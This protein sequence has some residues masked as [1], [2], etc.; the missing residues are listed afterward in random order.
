MLYFL[1]LLCLSTSPNWA[2]LNQMPAEVLGFWRL[3]LAALILILFQTL[4]SEF[5]RLKMNRQNIWVIVSGFFFF[6][7]LWTYKYAA[8]HTTISTMMVMF[9]TNPIWASVGSRI[10]FN[11]K[12]ARRV[13][14]AYFLALAGVIV[15]VY[16][17]LSF[18]REHTNGNLIALISA[19]L[20]SF[21]MLTGKKA[22]ET[23][24][25]QVYAT[26][27]YLLCAVLFLFVSLFNE[28][29]LISIDYGTISWVAVA[30]LIIFPTFL[31][32]FLLTNLVKTMNMAI[33]SCGKL[34]EPIIGSIIA[35][36]VFKEAITSTFAVAFVLTALSIIILFWPQIK[37]YFY[38]K[39]HENSSSRRPN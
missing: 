12:I 19:A 23:H 8:K 9:S 31:G 29:P 16:D 39:P 25:N 14:T 17:S 4:R 5:P 26:Y 6:L 33:L 22:R 37:K 28:Q 3:A 11:E 32:H 10:F 21:Y 30:G 15:L 13:Y 27:Q 7:H 1:A 20:Y 38:T 2:K 18:S 34:I 36:F 35:Y 24:S